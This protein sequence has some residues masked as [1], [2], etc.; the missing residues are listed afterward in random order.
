MAGNEALFTGSR[1]STDNTW[2]VVAKQVLLVVNLNETQVEGDEGQCA[3][4][5]ALEGFM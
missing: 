2:Y 1:W 5:Q 3:I 4:F